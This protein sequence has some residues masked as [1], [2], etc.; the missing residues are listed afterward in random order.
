MKFGVLYGVRLNIVGKI[1]FLRVFSL[2]DFSDGFNEYSD[3]I[4][5]S[6]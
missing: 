5:L 4:L 1:V 6:G 3:N 2:G